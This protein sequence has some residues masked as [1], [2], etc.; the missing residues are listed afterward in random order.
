MDELIYYTNT[1]AI[2]LLVVIVATGWFV[3]RC[4]ASFLH[5][6]PKPVI[7]VRETARVRHKT[8]LARRYGAK[9]GLSNFTDILSVLKMESTSYEFKWAGFKTWSIELD[10]QDMFIVKNVSEADWFISNKYASRN[11]L[12][13]IIKNTG[14]TSADLS[15][16]LRAI[17]FSFSPRA[18]M[19]IGETIR[20]QKR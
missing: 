14:P 7:S 6:E 4:V 5:R 1:E 10:S 2:T 20:R 12:R 15:V 17:P 16:L 8:M 3:R 9:A 18:S 13:L 19:Y 11:N